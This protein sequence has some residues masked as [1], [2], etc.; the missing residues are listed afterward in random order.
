MFSSPYPVGKRPE[1]KQVPSSKWSI[2]HLVSTKQ[3]KTAQFVPASPAR[4]SSPPPR[5]PRQEEH[6]F[7]SN[8][9]GETPIS[10]DSLIS[11]VN[12]IIGSTT[13]IERPEAFDWNKNIPA[14]E[15]YDGV[16]TIGSESVGDPA[17]TLKEQPTGA[18]KQDT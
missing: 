12:S 15:F 5:S 2:S 16:S 18:S 9:A 6:E 13:T 3:M 1:L 11:P 10:E 7:P 14:F 17:T 4:R 8:L